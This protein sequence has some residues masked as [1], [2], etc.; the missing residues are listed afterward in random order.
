MKPTDSRQG[1]DLASGW[2]DRRCNSPNGCV[3][4]KPEMSSVF[5]IVEQI[6]RHQTF[7]MPL[8]Q[9][10]HVV[11]QVAPATS[12]PALRNT[13]LPWTA[14]GSA[15][16]LASHLPHSRNHIGS[17]LCVSVEEQE[18]VRLLVGPGFSQLLYNPKRIGI[19]CHSEVQDLTPLVADHEKA[20][21]NTKRERWDGEEV[22]RRNG[23]AMVSQER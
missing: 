22:H 14:K 17:K 10:D 4:P 18:S 8:I 13:V 16:W 6:Q 23:L 19:S 9:N 2:R 12:N 15:S 5:V 3:L 11:K 21:K 7:K 1:Y 20:V